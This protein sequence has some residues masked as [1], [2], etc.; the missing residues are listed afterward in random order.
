MRGC[1]AAGERGSSP[2]P[3]FP[4]IVSCDFETRST[5]DLRKAGTH[6]YAAH[7]TTDVW[8]LAYAFDDEEPELWTP[9]QPFP[10]RL[11]SAVTAGAE[12]RAWNAQFERVIWRHVLTQRRGVPSPDMRQWVCT[13]AEAAAMNLPRAL[14]D[15]ARVLGVAQQKD[16]PGHMYVLRM[17]QPRS[18]RGKALVWWDVAERLERLYTYCKQDVRTERSVARALRRL[19]P[20][21]REI[22]LLDQQIN[23]RGVGIDT[24]L[25]R[26]M[27]TIAQRAAEEANAQL[28]RTTRGNVGA[29]TQVAELTAWVRARGV[30]CDGVRKA[31]VRNLLAGSALPADVRE[32]LTLRQEAGRSSAAKLTSMLNAVSGDRRARGLLLYHGAG[33]GRWSG[34]RIQPHNFPRGDFDYRPFLALLH[35]GDYDTLSLITPPLQVVSAALRGVIV[36]AAGH[37]LMVGDF[38]QIEAR[39]LAWC[40]GQDDQLALFRAGQSPYPPMAEAIYSLPPG[41]INSKTD[42]RYKIGKDTVLGCGYGMGA[43]KFRTQILEKEGHDVGMELAERAVR[44]Y[45]DTMTAVTSLWRHAERAAIAAV[46]APGSE[47]RLA[48]CVFTKRGGYLYIVLPSKRPLCYARPRIMPRETPW[49][50]VKAAVVAEYVDPITKRWGPR[51]LYGGLLVENIVQAIA[52]DLMADAMLRQEQAGYPI[53]LTVHDEVIADVLDGHGSVAEFTALAETVPEWARGCPVA[54]KAWE[55][56]RWRK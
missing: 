51:A 35:A 48:G 21:E 53:I 15:C 19:T 50:A 9:E 3:H 41:T 17:A 33:T 47:Q 40:A 7:P 2:R 27:R 12:F 52:R 39:V 31:V 23:D 4:M 14:G 29:V 26:R 16:Q 38:E 36:P 45:R 44:T 56:D 10:E 25:V 13:A 6:V 11:V 30:E 46:Q 8:C 54:F 18:R 32:A 1:V 49:G 43:D 28:A 37:H 55:G 20:H 5:V 22:F 34:R 24:A 42:P